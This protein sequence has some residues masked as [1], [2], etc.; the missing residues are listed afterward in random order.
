MA[1]QNKQETKFSASL[2][3]E[4][5]KTLA[6]GEAA[7]DLQNPCVIFWPKHLSVQA[8]ALNEAKRLRLD[9]CCD[10]EVDRI[11]S[12]TQEDSFYC[13]VFTVV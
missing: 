1:P 9:D 2:L 5:E 4:A 7:L 13:R 6:I 8:A 12:I 11:E 10:F 3:N